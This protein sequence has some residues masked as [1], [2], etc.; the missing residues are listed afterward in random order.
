MKDA[1]N[2]I[3]VS[4]SWSHGVTTNMFIV[5][6]GQWSPRG[7]DTIHWS[8][9]PTPWSQYGLPPHNAEKCRSGGESDQSEADQAPGRVIIIIHSL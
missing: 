9:Y 6:T 5:N 8:V 1:P 3:I 2:V 4:I 7:P